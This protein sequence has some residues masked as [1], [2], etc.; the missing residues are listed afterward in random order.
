MGRRHG[1]V[2]EWVEDC[3]HDNYSGA[4]TDGAPWTEG[5]D[6][7]RRVVRGGSWTHHPQIL[8]AAFRHRFTIETD[9]RALNLGFRL[10][11]TL[12]P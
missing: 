5:A 8:R 12:T 4:P 10:G 3:Y 9:L 1:N 6:C 2:W 11:R 7:S